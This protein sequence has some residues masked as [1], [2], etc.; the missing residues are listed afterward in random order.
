MNSAS[1]S[2]TSDQDEI[3][4]FNGIDGTTGGY[5]LPVMTPAEVASIAKG[6]RLDRDHLFDLKLRHRQAT[7]TRR[8]IKEGLDPQLLS[9]AGWGVIFA[10]QD[11]D[12]IPA[13]KE[14]LGELLNLR[15]QQAGER[16]REYSG[17]NAC[18]PGESKSSFLGRQGAGPGPVDPDKMPFYLLIVADPASIPYSFQ[19]QLDVQYAVGRIHFENMDEYAHYAHS[20]VAAE[21]GPIAL[22][23]KASF[24]GVENPDDRATQLSANLLVQPLADLF[25][26]DRSRSGW[27]IQ[28]T[29]GKDATK[30]ALSDNLTAHDSPALI[31]SASHGMGFPNADPRQR[32]HQGALLCQDWPGPL[33]WR[34]PIPEEY[35]LSA[36]DIASDAHLLGKLAILFACYGAGTPQMDEFTQVYFREPTSI[37]PHAFIARLT[38]RL[39]GHPNGGMLAVLGHVD[40]TWSCSFTW[41]NAGSQLAVFESALKRLMAGQQV[42]LAMEYFN[43]RYAELSSMLTEELQSARF[44]KLIDTLDMAG[45]WTANNDARSYVVIGDPA[46]RL[47]VSAQTNILGQSAAETAF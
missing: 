30:A 44:G 4:I 28:A 12:K 10:F 11:Q 24:F 7:E 41:K 3:L 8:R 19:Y 20:V 29:L 9:Q 23:P 45:M 46:A 47:R 25:E 26:A 14:A 21:T 1:N 22:P 34:G 17:V 39:L 5:L 15:Q 16:Y 43:E 40:R 18:R 27:E 33:A 6:E 32:P 38:Q 37:A 13:L 2:S 36:D 35:Y 42:G 31:F